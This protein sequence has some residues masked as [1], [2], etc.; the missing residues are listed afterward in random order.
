MSPYFFQYL[1]L[2]WISTWN[3]HSTILVFFL[4]FF[5]SAFFSSLSGNGEGDGNGNGHGNGNIHGNVHGD[6][7]HL[8]WFHF[9]LTLNLRSLSANIQ[10]LLK[11]RQKIR[12][13]FQCQIW[14][15]IQIPAKELK[16]SRQQSAVSCK[17]SQLP[18][19][20]PR[21]GWL[22]CLC[23]MTKHHLSLLNGRRD[24]S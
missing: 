8:D 23:T 13:Q 12:I 6:N 21:G 20:G 18:G 24:T 7:S 10:F 17:L 9:S 3:N 1:R 22:A 5:N 16:Q 14:I 11:I 4:N 15:Q 2:A 19:P